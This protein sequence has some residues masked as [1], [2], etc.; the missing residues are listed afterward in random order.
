[1]T[2]FVE[3]SEDEE[4]DPALD[5]WHEA[6]NENGAPALTAAADVALALAIDGEARAAALAFQAA[7]AEPM[8]HENYWS[9]WPVP[10]MM[11]MLIAL[12]LLD[13]IKTLTP[14]D[15]DQDWASQQ[16]DRILDVT[17]GI[18]EERLAISGASYRRDELLQFVN[19]APHYRLVR[20]LLADDAAARRAAALRP[21]CL[22]RTFH[23]TTHSKPATRPASEWG[24]VPASV[25]EA[26]DQMLD[27]DP[28]AWTRLRH[29]AHLALTAIVAD[30]FLHTAGPTRSLLRHLQIRRFWLD[31]PDRSSLLAPD[32][33]TRGF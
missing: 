16:L 15:D 5:W 12:A 32:E 13:T 19:A 27:D 31:Q 3:S 29:R 24:T 21:P 30:P 18:K 17:E 20:D 4:Y 23:S 28:S 25:A 11:V 22:E 2:D 33:S 6:A 14:V 9:L 7:G 10:N 1:M 26:F 8:R